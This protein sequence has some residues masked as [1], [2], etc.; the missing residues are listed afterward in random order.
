[1]RIGKLLALET[2]SIWNQSNPWPPMNVVV[3][4]YLTMV[5]VRLTCVYDR[6][7]LKTASKSLIGATSAKD[8]AASKAIT[9]VDTKNESILG[10]KTECRDER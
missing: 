3:G 5:L 2:L 8:K 7:T 6:Q 1:M 10:E 4:L 9:I